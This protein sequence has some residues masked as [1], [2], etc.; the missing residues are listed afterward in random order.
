MQDLGT[1]LQS[2][3]QFNLNL[4]QRTTSS[5]QGLPGDYGPQEF[6]FNQNQYS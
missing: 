1:E 4:R 2:E 3:N 6:K 5:D